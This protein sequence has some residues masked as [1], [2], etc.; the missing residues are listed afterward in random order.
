M[1]LK[2]S[3]QGRDEKEE[4]RLKNSLL[5]MSTVAQRNGDIFSLIIRMQ[6]TIMHFIPN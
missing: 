4:S 1:I 2:I 3:P 5:F 6:T